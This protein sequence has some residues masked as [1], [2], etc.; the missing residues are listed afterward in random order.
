MKERIA[1]LEGES[2]EKDSAIDKATR[3]ID[4]LTK[5]VKTQYY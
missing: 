1:Y 5:D 4:L 3:I 2:I